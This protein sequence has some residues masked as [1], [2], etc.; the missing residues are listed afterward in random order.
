VRI[1]DSVISGN[2]VAP[3]RTANIGPPCPSGPCPFAGAVGGGIDAWGPLTLDHTVVQN[4]LVGKAAGLSNVA[5]D[6]QSGGIQS[7]NGPLT[8]RSSTITGNVA[9]ASA[10]NGRFA[11]TGG[12]F[13]EHGTLRLL[14][15]TITDNLAALD[16]AFPS[17]VETGAIA[18]GVHASDPGAVVHDTTISRNVVRMTNSAGNASAFAGAINLDQRQGDMRNVTL[19]DNRAEA[20]ATGPVGDAAA[21]SAGGEIGG[22]LVGVRLTGNTLTVRSAHGDATAIGGGGIV[23]GTLTGGLIAN[24]V[25]RAVSPH[26]TATLY[27]GGITVESGLTLRGTPVTGNIGAASGASGRALGGGIL[28]IDVPDGPPAGLLRLIDSPVTDNQ[29]QAGSGVARHG[30]GVDSTAPVVRRNSPVVDN[31]PD[32]CVGC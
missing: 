19:A 11:D 25:G 21:D 1:S 10:P 28:D 17:S 7:W 24:N 20:A 9:T 32:Q 6:A 29:L 14:G 26:G 15:S 12:V 5:S 27:G 31:A 2:R 18:G 3:S 22:V 13:A 23:G 16:A 30:G 8:I 4:N